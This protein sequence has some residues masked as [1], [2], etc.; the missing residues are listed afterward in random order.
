MIDLRHKNLFFNL[1]T[2]S[3][4]DDIIDEQLKLFSIDGNYVNCYQPLSTLKKCYYHNYITFEID[5]FRY[6]LVISFG[7]TKQVD[8]VFGLNKFK[9]MQ[10]GNK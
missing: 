3:N 8:Y 1:Y 4:N 10:R 6:R 2:Y 5:L 7:L 9:A